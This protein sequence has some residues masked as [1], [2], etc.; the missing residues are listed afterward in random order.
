MSDIPSVQW[1][2]GHMAKTRRLIVEN[3]K[4]VDVA[5]ELLD[6]RIPRSSRNPL[7]SELLGSKP[8]LVALNKADLADK[9]A[10]RRWVAR[11]AADGVSAV[12]VNSVN[13]SGVD[14]LVK[15]AADIGRQR[16]AKLIGK[17]FTARPTRA[18]IVGIPNVGKSSLVNRLA[19]K[20]GAKVENRPGVTR[21]KQ[22]L[23]LRD[24]LDLLDMPGLL[25]P[26]FD[27]PLVGRNLALVGS[28]SGEVF[29]V[30]LMAASLLAWLREHA[31]QKLAA[32]YQLT[33]A[34]LAGDDLLPIIGRKRGCLAKAGAVDRDKTNR[35][36][37]AEFRNGKLGGITLEE[38]S[39][40]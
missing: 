23:R 33:A 17:G 34:D 31:P 3:L 30:E 38:V 27:D 24:D 22:W 36:L 13:G 37:L 7:L 19:G 26:K 12:A 6:A 25:W 5:V 20:A 8:R 16:Q 32:R 35:L 21:N 2:P 40:P 14:R 1:F 9:A 10:T 15:L 28:V 11:F 18:M 39:E 4:L 29:D